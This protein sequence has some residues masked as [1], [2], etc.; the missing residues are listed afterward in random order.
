MLHYSIF[1]NYFNFIKLAAKIFL[2]NYL[3]LKSILINFILINLFIKLLK[4]V[5]LWLVFYLFLEN[6]Q[7]SWLFDQNEKYLKFHFHILH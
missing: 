2:I 3:T 4:E 6:S 5:L 7:L 1:L